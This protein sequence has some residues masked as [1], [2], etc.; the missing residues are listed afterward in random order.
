MSKAIK[1]KD[2]K[3]SRINFFSDEVTNS[4]SGIDD[5]NPVF[6]AGT[7]VNGEI[8]FNDLKK[9]EF[10]LSIENGVLYINTYD[11]VSVDL[12]LG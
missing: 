4:W 5:D 2:R 10:R 3:I 8:F 12:E 11:R 9:L 6:T 7:Q 1:I